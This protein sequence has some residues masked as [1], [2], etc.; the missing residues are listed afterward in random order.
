MARWHVK[1]LNIKD[2]LCTILTL[3]LLLPF[4]VL[5]ISNNSVDWR[6]ICPPLACDSTQGKTTL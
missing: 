4:A 6:N 3:L 1:V 5:Q 2:K